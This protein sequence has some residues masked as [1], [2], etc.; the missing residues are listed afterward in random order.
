MN[1]QAFGYPVAN[2]ETIFSKLAS[3]CLLSST[4]RKPIGL[5]IHLIPHPYHKTRDG[6]WPDPTWAYFWPSVYKRPTRLW[7]RY[8]L[9][10]PE[11]NFFDSKGKNWKIWRFWGKY[12]KLKLKLWMADP[13]Q[14]DPT[15]VKNF[16]PRP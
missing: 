9:T 2:F 8:F 14:P 7:P 1:Q 16:W 13:A 11:E 10:R 12:S 3:W 5:S 15:Q 6:P 4:L